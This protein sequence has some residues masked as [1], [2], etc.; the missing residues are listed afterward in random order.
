LRRLA[1]AMRVIV[2]AVRVLIEAVV[3]SKKENP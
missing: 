1:K 2:E 3:N